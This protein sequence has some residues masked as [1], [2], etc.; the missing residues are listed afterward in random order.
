MSRTIAVMGTGYVGLITAVGLA[1]FG[2]RVVGVDTNAKIVDSLAKGVATIYEL[3]VADYLERNVRAGRLSFTTEA[4]IAI[5]DAS[6]VFIAVG[7][8]G[9]PDGTADLSQVDSAIQSISR[10]ASRPKIIVVKSTVPSV[11]T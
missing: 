2:N 7:T 5:R 1:D 6:V 3:G 11:S 4:D 10:I 9:N 8:P